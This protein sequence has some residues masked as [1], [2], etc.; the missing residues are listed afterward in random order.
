MVSE[1]GTV[2]ILL[3]EL[4]RYW[5]QSPFCLCALYMDTRDANYDTLNSN[6]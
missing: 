4:V 6:K 2:D 1:K 3:D 5:L